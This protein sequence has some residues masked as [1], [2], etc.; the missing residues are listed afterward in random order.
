M[1]DVSLLILI[2]VC[3]A[4]SVSILFQRYKNAIWWSGVFQSAFAYIFHQHFD[5][6]KE[7]KLAND[8]EEYIIWWPKIK[9]I[10]NEQTNNNHLWIVI[11]G[12]MK[13]LSECIEVLEKDYNAFD[14]SDFCVY[15]QPGIRINIQD[16]TLMKNKPTPPPTNIDY[17]FEFIQQIHSTQK[18]KKISV[19][20]LSMGALSSLFLVDKLSKYENKKYVEQIVMIHSPEFIRE[21]FESLYSNWIFRFDILCARHV[22]KFNISSGSWKIGNLQSKMKSKWISGWPFMKEITEH[23]V[24][25]KWNDFEFDLYNPH[26]VLLQ[27][28]KNGKIKCCDL[29]RIISKNDPIVPFYSINKE[30]FKYYQEVVVLDKGGHCVACPKIASKVSKW[31]KQIINNTQN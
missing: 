26:R 6:R 19:I 2:A 9:R 24:G 20:G 30:Y 15:N 3:V 25:G 31:N 22:Y 18:Y 4:L 8:G 17:L 10:M 27:N 5:Y 13:K 11:P 28:E 14:R 7:V 29:K 23:I 16:G 21:T 1:V 12:A